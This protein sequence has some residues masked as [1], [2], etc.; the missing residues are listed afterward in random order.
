MSTRSPAKQASLARKLIRFYKDLQPPAS[1][2]RGVELLYPHK[3]KETMNVVSGFFKKYYSTDHKRRLIFGINPG[4]FGA[5]ITGINFTAPRQLKEHCGIDHPFGQKSEL[6]AEFIYEMILR[7]GGV[8]AF[9]NNYFISAVSPL[10]Y[11]RNGI[12]L[13]YYDDKKLL[14]A[15]KPFIVSSI[16]KLISFGFRTDRC[17]CI[18]GAKNFDYLSALN[19]EYGFFKLIVPLPHPRFILQ[20]RRKYKE[21]HIRRYLSVFQI[22]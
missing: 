10:G 13:N 1:L 19:E 20:Y 22:N 12:N 3:Q 16:Q 9:Y 2:P 8:E 5:G 15:T 7:Y 17:I 6:S 4:R 11:T 18:G 21:D 14:A